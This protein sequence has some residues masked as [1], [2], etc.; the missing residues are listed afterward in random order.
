MI[1]VVV[2][3]AIVRRKGEDWEG[4]EGKGRGGMGQI[5]MTRGAS[6]ILG[7]YIIG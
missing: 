1:V 7:V 6:I 5:A 2:N 3:P 4:M